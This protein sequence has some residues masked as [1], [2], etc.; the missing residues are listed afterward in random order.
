MK[1]TITEAEIAALKAQAVEEK[2]THEEIMELLHQRRIELMKPERQ[3]EIIKRGR[4]DEINDLLEACHLPREFEDVYCSP[5]I[6]LSA[7]AQLCI[8]RTDNNDFITKML[9]ETKLAP[10]F[11]KK[12]IDEWIESQGI[13]SDDFDNYAWENSGLYQKL[14]AEGE[15]YLIKKSLERAQKQDKGKELRRIINY[16]EN[17]TLSDEAQIALMDCLKIP[18]GRDSLLDMG[19]A[20]VVQY[21][22]RGLCLEAQKLLIAHGD[23]ELILDYIQRS[24][25]GLEVE[26]DLLKRGNREE[27]EAYF[28]RYSFL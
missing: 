27:I 17:Y 28:A 5:Q 13:E 22:G 21:I 11:E 6:N 1:K 9:R 19:R 3:M 26:E 2:N 10:E 25:R 23:S 8:Y 12:L 4:T 24:E 18:S 16:Y 7:D 20:C 14:S 15:V